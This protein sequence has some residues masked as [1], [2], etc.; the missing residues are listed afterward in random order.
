MKIGLSGRR[1]LPPTQT[2]L[3]LTKN[4]LLGK[5]SEHSYLA[6]R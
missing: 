6:E 5:K 4:P 2:Q 1:L 3:R